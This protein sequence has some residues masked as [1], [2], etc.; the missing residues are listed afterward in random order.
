MKRIKHLITVV[1]VMTL[2][3][4]FNACSEWLEVYPQ[5]NQVSDYYWSSKEEVDAMLNGC[6]YYYRNMVSSQLIPLG[7]LRAG[8]IFS[9]SSNTNLQEF[10]IKETDNIS[11]WGPFTK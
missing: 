1:L 9:R 4:T 2:A 7:E 11:N 8:Q 10:R 6:Y 5:N 3:S